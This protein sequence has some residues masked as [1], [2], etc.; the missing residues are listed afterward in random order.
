MAE[1]ATLA[2]PYANAV[3]DLARST[4]RMTEWSPML[5]LLARAVKTDEV[6]ALV[7]LPSLAPAVK[8]HRLIELVREEVD[9]RCRRFVNV[10]ADNHRLELLPEI[11]AQFEALKAEAEKTL[12]VEITSAVELTDRQ[13]DAYA[14]ALR[15]RFEQEVDVKVE[16]DRGLVGGA[17]IRAGDTVIDGSVRGRLTR[18]VESLQRN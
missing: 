13:V 4:G 2:R 15:G 7:A 5:G 18:L 12:D 6:R 11:A 14:T 1:T 8:A 16:I 10:L 3:F 17:V 9:D